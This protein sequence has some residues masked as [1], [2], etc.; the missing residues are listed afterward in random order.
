MPARKFS[1]SRL[2]MR[3]AIPK[4]RLMAY[5]AGRGLPRTA[6]IRSATLLVTKESF[7][8]GI[9]HV[10]GTDIGANLPDCTCT[11]RTTTRRPSRAHATVFS[12]NEIDDRVR[13]AITYAPVSVH[14]ASSPRAIIAYWRRRN[15]SRHCVPPS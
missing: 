5:K 1:E 9:R 13:A 10:A 15:S 7:S 12:I 8:R 14:C 6:V 4:R 2:G 11:S 3:N